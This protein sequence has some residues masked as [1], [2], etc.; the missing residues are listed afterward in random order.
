MRRPYIIHIGDE[1]YTVKHTR[2]AP[3]VD[4]NECH[5]TI[6]HFNRIIHIHDKDPEE[7]KL[8]TLIHEWMH[9]RHPEWTEEAVTL[10]ADQ[11]TDGIIVLQE[12]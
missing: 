2:K 5:G 6:D 11:L 3:R 8:N 1:K 4:G 10:A 9:R 7:E 12:D